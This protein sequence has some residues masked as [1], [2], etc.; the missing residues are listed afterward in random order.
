MEKEKIYDFSKPIEEVKTNFIS[1]LDLLNMKI[2]S[3]PYLFDGII[4]QV[5]AW[6]LVGASDTAKSMLLRQLVM[7]VVGN[8]P[9]LDWKCNAIH[10]NAIVVCSE[11]DEFAISYLLRKQNKTIGLSNDQAQNIRFLFDTEDFIQKLEI[12]LST[13]PADLIILDAFGDLFDGKDMNQNNQ[14]RAF[15]NKFTLIANKYKCSIGFL[16]HTGKRTEEL[17]PSK[18]N[19]IGSQGFE[20]KMR[21]VIELRLD[22]NES[23]L[24]HLCVVKG[25]YLPQDQ[26]TSSTV[27]RMDENLTFTNTGERVEYD[28]MGASG[29]R[30]NTKIE[31]SK[32][33]IAAHYVCIR[34]ILL[35]GKNYSQNELVKKFMH[36]WNI[37]DKVAR[38]FV[39]YYNTQNWIVDVST[40][41]D[42]R[43]YR[44]N[45][46]VLEAPEPEKVVEETLNIFDNE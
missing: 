43:K 4:P 2:D 38:R 39:D 7:C 21:L 17:A 18:N 42:R 41:P 32:L 26:K 19:A 30:I 46:T 1:G 44:E 45:L 37:S 14:V 13:Q 10:K 16:H 22:K 35:I 33:E 3:I 23:D 8:I 29:E 15:L 40:N 31:P 5:G 28:A 20:A 25:N 24:R 27:I 11:D 36:H 12:E 6:A 34:T 9:F